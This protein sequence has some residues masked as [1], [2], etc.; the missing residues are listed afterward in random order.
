LLEPTNEPYA[1]AKIA[2][3]KLC[4]SYN[5]QYGSSHGVDYRAVMPTNLYGLGDNYHPDNSHVIPGLIRRFHQAKIFRKDSVTI[6]GTGVPRREF[7][8]VDDMAAACIH[9]MNLPKI[10]FDAA[11]G[12]KHI[13]VNVGYGS[14]ISIAELA[15]IVG[16][17]IGYSGE[18]QFDLTK[19]DGAPRKLLD[20]SR[21][22]ALG[23]QPT[24]MLEDG[25]A[26]AYK[27]FLAKSY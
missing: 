24:T 17:V 14:D 2:G 21:M 16:S 7:L 1:I 23:W 8:F 13:H 9:V 11:I 26:V 12:S 20:S 4:E 6:W 15:R 18:I 5:R 10:A 27:E 3:L 19:P 22:N 25:L